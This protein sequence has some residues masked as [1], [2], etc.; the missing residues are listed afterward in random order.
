M[1]YIDIE[2]YKLKII[3]PIYMNDLQHS[4]L[5]RLSILLLYN[6]AGVVRLL[7]LGLFSAYSDFANP[8]DIIRDVFLSDET[9]Y[10]R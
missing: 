9:K 2:Y 7:R 1:N 5:F 6:L 4:E 8:V 10:N 3:S